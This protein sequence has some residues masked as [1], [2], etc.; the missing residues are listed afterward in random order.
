MDVTTDIYPSDTNPA[1]IDIIGNIALHHAACPPH[2]N[3][4][5]GEKYIERVQKLLEQYPDGAL[6]K[7]QFD[8]IPLHY[9]LDCS[10]PCYQIVRLLV[11]AYPRGIWETDVDNI[12]PCKYR[13]ISFYLSFNCYFR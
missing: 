12:S 7:N 5:C 2:Q 11:N 10:S 3:T 1:D 6:T 9:S 13:S 4:L 8:R